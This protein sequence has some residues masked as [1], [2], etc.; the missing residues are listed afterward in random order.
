MF[1][2]ACLRIYVCSFHYVSSLRHFHS[3]VKLW[4]ENILVKIGPCSTIIISTY[5]WVELKPS[6]YLMENGYI[7]YI[8]KILFVIIVLNLVQVRPGNVI[9]RKGCFSITSPTDLVLNSFSMHTPNWSYLYYLHVLCFSG[10]GWF[11]EKIS[12]NWLI[13][14]FLINILEVLFVILYILMLLLS[15]L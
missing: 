9:E 6:I 15:C 13:D 11:R 8:P 3:V 7:R 10:L 4:S 12:G 1:W 2:C 5:Q 14:L